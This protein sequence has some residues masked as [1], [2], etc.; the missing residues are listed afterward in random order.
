M[1]IALTVVTAGLLS[2]ISVARPAGAQDRLTPTP[3]DDTSP[4]RAPRSLSLDQAQQVYVQ[5]GSAMARLGQLGVEAA[6]QHRRAVAADYF[7]QF[8]TTFWNLHFN[9]FMGEQISVTRPIF[10]STLTAGFPL[11]GQNQSFIAVNFVQPITPLLKVHQAVNIARADENIARGK[12]GLPV[13]EA[14]RAVEKDYF[15]LLIAQRELALVRLRGPIGPNRGVAASNGPFVVNTARI[16]PAAPDVVAMLDLTNRVK[17]LT[18]SLNESLGWPADTPLELDTPAP[19]AEGL[20]LQQ[21]VDKALATNPEV[22]E[23]QQTV[24]K[25]RAATKVSKLDYVPDI[26]VIGGWAFQDDAVPL[27]PNNFGYVGVMGSYNLFNF[28]K[29][30]YSI[31]ERSTQ[32][33]MAQTALELTKAKVAAA[34]KTGFLELERAREQSDLAQL[35]PLPRVRDARDDREFQFANARRSLDQL[36]LDYRHRRLY[37]ELMALL[38]D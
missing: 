23:A 26:A 11:L 38:G 34:V 13:L 15:D 9:Q 21:A 14:R 6:E 19:L 2:L 24:E 30:E 7:P 4:A 29:R 20:S 25:A 35:Q 8:S 32:L 36:Q 5:P 37:A 31:K 3:P 16:E 17:T 1:K 28:G 18:A 12:A 22:I 27:L 33:K 10:G